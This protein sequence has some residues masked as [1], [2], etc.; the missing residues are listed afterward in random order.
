VKKPY[1][2]EKLY[3]ALPYLY[4]IAGLVTMIV[5]RNWM[6]VFSGMALLLAAGNV[7]QLRYRYRL[8]AA[9][10][11][12][13]RTAVDA[14][15]PLPHPDHLIQIVW[16]SAIETGHPVIDAQ[17]RRL[18]RM[19]NE[20]IN[21]VVADKDKAELI[22][23]LEELIEHIESHF[24]TE[25]S[26][27]SEIAHPLFEMHRAL[28]RGLLTRAHALFQQFQHNQIPSGDF[29]G[30]IA[31][32]L[33]LNHIAKDDQRFAGDVMPRKTVWEDQP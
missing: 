4:A 31:Y 6:A 21:A 25:E 8:L 5:V 18:F 12:S 32:D 17:H 15:S 23:Q 33:I 26:I 9:K 30:F 28:H 1:L 14:A 13:S 11:T 10:R 20:V 27:L 16:K 19:A 22:P 7:W 29:V 24:R 3:N 2:P